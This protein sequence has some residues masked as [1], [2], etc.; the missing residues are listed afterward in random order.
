MLSFDT[1]FHMRNCHHNQ[2]NAHIIS[3]SFR[4]L[5]PLIISQ[6]SL[7]HHSS[8][9]IVLPILL[10]LVCFPRISKGGMILLHLGSFTQH[11]ILRFMLVE[12]YCVSGSF[13]FIVVSSLSSMEILPTVYPSVDRYLGCFHTK[14]CCEHS[15]S[16]LYM[17]FM[18]SL[19]LG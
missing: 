8:A 5:A 17:G 9:I 6:S 4:R 2:D 19:L 16:S 1:C 14:S 12:C 7:C 3:E 11:N 15:R 10:S 13:L 18:F